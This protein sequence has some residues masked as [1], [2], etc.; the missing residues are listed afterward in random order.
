[1][2]A[3]L[4]GSTAAENGANPSAGAFVMFDPISGPKNSPLDARTIASWSGGTPTYANDVNNRSTGGL[5]TGIGFGAQDI[6]GAGDSRTPKRF[7]DG[8]FADDYVP[9]LTAIGTLVSGSVPAVTPDATDSRYLYI[10]GGRT[11]IVAGKPVDTPYTAGFLLCG[12]GNGASRDAGAGPAFTG[13]AVKTVTVS[14]TPAANGGV[15]ETGFTNR[16]GVTIPVG[17][18]TFGSATAASA[19]PAEEAEPEVTADA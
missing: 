11:N 17:Q 13:F 7:A 6:F 3:S 9:G 16:S 1:M 18:S 8:N 10:G 14:G 5:A 19:A 2:P 4:P 12:A 15:V